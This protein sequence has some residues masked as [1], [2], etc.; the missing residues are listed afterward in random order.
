MDVLIHLVERAGEVVEREAFL[1]ALWPGT[2]VDDHALS[3]QVGEVRKAL[4]DRP[5]SPRFIETRHRRG[6]RFI[7]AVVRDD[8]P[9]PPIAAAPA[10]IPATADGVPETRYARSGDV[11]IAYQVIGEP[12]GID[13]VFVM[14]WVS[15]LEYFWK[16]PSFARF[17]R[18]LASFSRLILFDKRGTGLSDR[19]PIAQLPTLEQRMDDLRAVMDAAGSQQAA[20]LGVSEGGPMSALFSATY[21]DKTLAL[22]MIGT[23]ARRLWDHDYPWGPT[24]EQR[25]HFFQ[26][27]QASWGGP[28]GIEERAS[29]VAHDPAF[30]D[31]WA[32]YLRMGASPGAAIALTKMNADID[33]R[34]VLPSVRVPALV[35]HRTGDQLL[36]V[37]EGRYVASLI[38]GARF[39]ELPGV[40]HLPFVGDQDE[41][42]DGIED[43]LSSLR[44][45][46][47]PERV[48]ATVMLVSSMDPGQYH[49]IDSYVAREIEWFRGK[50]LETPGAI[51]AA[52]DGPARAARCAAAIIRHAHR[53]GVSAR[54]AVHSGECEMLEGRIQGGPAVGVAARILATALASE[55]LVS[56]A[57]RDLVAGSGIRFS[58]HGVLAGWNIYRVNTA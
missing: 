15:H 1:E 25:E 5:G 19:V 52:F 40:D 3:V 38:P 35:I 17:L 6:Y 22:V 13:I 45:D 57:V 43:F 34:Q 46:I 58:D 55:V 12:G 48:L 10:P 42:L 4:D 30:R 16:E 53:A 29:S 44:F 39:L 7:A 47:E 36:R 49:R 41:M 8:A 54:A 50:P 51:G 32:T 28:V 27:I 9:A 23:Y 33:V 24:A 2:Y 26:E 56:N 20:I 37:E 31:W 18:R 14:G 21:P 11:D